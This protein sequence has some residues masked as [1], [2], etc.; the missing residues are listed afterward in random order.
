MVVISS[1]V[2]LIRFCRWYVVVAFA[3]IVSRSS[4]LSCFALPC[5]SQ[6]HNRCA[7]SNGSLL[8][9]STLSLVHVTNF[10]VLEIFNSN[11]MLSSTFFF[12]LLSEFRRNLWTIEMVGSGLWGAQREQT[13]RFRIKS[14]ETHIFALFPTSI[15]HSSID[16]ENLLMDFLDDFKKRTL[17]TNCLSSFRTP[18]SDWWEEMEAQWSER[19]NTFFVSELFHPNE[20]ERM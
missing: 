4:S 3:V 10:F 6:A 8:S 13:R 2:L 14:F 9:L 5:F 17:T 11:R 18:A 1:R 20:S 12:S 15:H 7:K 16:I 19:R